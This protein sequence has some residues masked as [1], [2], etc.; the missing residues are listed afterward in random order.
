LRGQARGG[1]AKERPRLL[2]NAASRSQQATKSAI[3]F[4]LQC[5]AFGYESAMKLTLD[6]ERG[7]ASATQTPTVFEAIVR[8]R[9]LAATYNR[10][11]VTLAPHVIYT[12]HDEL[13]I[14][15]V[16][17]DRDGKPPKEVKVGT[18]KLAGLGAVR[19]T[20]RSFAPYS[21]F[22]AND[23]KYAGVALLMVEPA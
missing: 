4:L 15:A 11:D 14:D 3:R 19:L 17:V 10:T 9:C 5:S 2:A 1:L 18:F 13:F 16:V 20:P 22:D 23:A 21:V 6:K 7:D 12:R 8:R